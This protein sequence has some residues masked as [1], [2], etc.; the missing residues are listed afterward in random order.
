M[1][2]SEARQLWLGETDCRAAGE[3]RAPNAFVRSRM[4]DETLLADYALVR[5][6][7][8]AAFA[9]D[10]HA[11][12]GRVGETPRVICGDEAPARAQPV[13]TSSAETPTTGKASSRTASKQA[14][15]ARKPKAAGN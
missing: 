11:R 7:P 12:M 5:G 9:I 3:G 2:F 4:C 1:H 8:Q 6:N 15:K 14:R 13:A 10:L